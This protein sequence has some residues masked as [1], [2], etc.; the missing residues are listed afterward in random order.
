[1]HELGEEYY[2]EDPENS[3]DKSYN[4]D[5]LSLQYLRDQNQN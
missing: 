5:D 3:N 1:M 4:Q 2:H